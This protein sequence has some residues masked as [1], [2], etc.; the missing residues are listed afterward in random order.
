MMICIAHSSDKGRDNDDL[1]CP[2]HEKD[3]QQNAE[4]ERWASDT[5][6]GHK[7]K[8][9]SP[10]IV[11]KISHQQLSGRY[12]TSNCLEDISPAT[13]WKISHQQL[14]GRYLTSNCLEDISPAIV[15]RI[16]HQQ[17][18][19]GEKHEKRKFLM[20]FLERTREGHQQSDEHWNHFK[21]NARETSERWGGA[22]MGF[23]ECI[24]TILNWTEVRVSFQL[25]NVLNVPLHL[26]LSPSK[27]PV[28]SKLSWRCHSSLLPHSDADIKRPLGR[29]WSEASNHGNKIS[30]TR[31]RIFL[32]SSN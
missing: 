2:Q 29:D 14:S 1:H 19:G 10:A 16:S 30:K 27:K 20:I 3:L 22:H 15:W 12:L 7:A 9:I 11:W 13:V 4:N 24:D 28:S 18:S 17:L 8:D 31:Q 23:F 26:P 6:W 21:G 25:D 5:T 32:P